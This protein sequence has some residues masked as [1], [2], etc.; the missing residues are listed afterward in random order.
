M[1]IQSKLNV[2]PDSANEPHAIQFKVGY[3]PLKIVKAVYGISESF[4]YKLYYARQLNLFKLENR[5]FVNT[6]E[7]ENLIQSGK[8][9]LR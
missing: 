2:G 9:T 4:I 3:I 7:L 5:T 6:I 8:K 1:D